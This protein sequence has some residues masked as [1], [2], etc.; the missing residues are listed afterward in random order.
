MVAGEGFG[1]Q[2]GILIGTHTAYLIMM[3]MFW[4]R[5]TW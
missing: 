3:K 2:E 5:K 1:G 4:K